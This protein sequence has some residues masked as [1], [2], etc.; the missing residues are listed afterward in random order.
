MSQVPPAQPF[1]PALASRPSTALNEGGRDATALAW[2]REMERAQMTQWF[3][4]TDTRV[5]APRPPPPPTEVLVRAAKPAHDSLVAA[6][7]R[8]SALTPPGL[9]ADHT[10]SKVHPL[11][12]SEGSTTHEQAKSQRAQATGA[13]GGRHAESVTL[14]A[15]ASEAGSH[16]SLAGSGAT[17][18]AYGPASGAL[19]LEKFALP[20]ASIDPESRVSLL[21]RVPVGASVGPRLQ[22]NTNEPPVQT[23]PLF[24]N[25]DT[26]S[27]PR[28]L[29][30]PIQHAARSAVAGA[31]AL[32]ETTG[33]TGVRCH[34]QWS[35]EGVHLWLGMNASVQEPA[36]QL[37]SIISQ[38]QQSLSQH[39]QMLATVVC[40]GRT[41]F[42][43]DSLESERLLAGNT[44]DG[45]IHDRLSFS[46]GTYTTLFQ[47]E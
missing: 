43:R 10:S 2:Q 22:T 6:A 15:P 19:Q 32:F 29:G 39:G 1:Q 8:P 28:N 27:A 18:A 23:T 14:A 25:A 7:E 45:S 20:H 34:A 9:L 12:R 38:L 47:Q 41:V 46:L 36:R 16:T 17:P 11:S 26:D 35:A 44:R 13:V 31:P 33:L 21:Q 24:D 3:H 5:V 4:T 30:A 42:Q 37:S 40:N